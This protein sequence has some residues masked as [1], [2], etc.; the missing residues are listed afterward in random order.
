VEKVKNPKFEMLYYGKKIAEG[1]Q[2]AELELYEEEND[3]WMKVQHEIYEMEHSAD[4]FA[5]LK[6]KGEEFV[7][8]RNRD[9]EPGAY[10][11]CEQKW[12]E[13]LTYKFEKKIGQLKH[14]LSK[15][16]Q[17]EQKFKASEH[18]EDFQMYYLENELKKLQEQVMLKMH[19]EK[20][21]PKSKDE[22][23]V[24]Q[25]LIQGKKAAEPEPEMQE[26]SEEQRKKFMAWEAE[27]FETEYSPSSK[28]KK[29]SLYLKQMEADYQLL[30]SFD[31]SL[32]KCEEF[33]REKIAITKKIMENEREKLIEICKVDEDT[34]MKVVQAKFDNSGDWEKVER[35]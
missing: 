18:K 27:Q 26:I 17:E 6:T 21:S 35:T 5:T 1:V 28:V 15:A 22:K 11:R 3:Q 14:K 20:N 34:I 2:F 29:L 4:F 9:F 24:P 13:L 23:E 10:A 30:Q 19:A 33:Y 8:A 25:K 31:S 16:E 12:K 7:S 32:P